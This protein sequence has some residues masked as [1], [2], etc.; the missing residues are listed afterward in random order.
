[1]NNINE[2]RLEYQIKPDLGPEASLQLFLTYEGTDDLLR[3]AHIYIICYHEKFTCFT[4]TILSRFS[5]RHLINFFYYIKFFIQWFI[6]T[7]NKYD[8]TA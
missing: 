8:N 1:M 2:V 6:K 4:V 3:S 5:A 7:S